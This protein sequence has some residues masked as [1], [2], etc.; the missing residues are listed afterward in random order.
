[1]EEG[2]SAL[3]APSPGPAAAAG[4]RGEHRAGDVAADER[5]H[6]HQEP[7]VPVRK[8][9]G[10]RE[11]GVPGAGQGV[12]PVPVWR[13]QRGRGRRQGLGGALGPLPGG[14]LLHLPL[15]LLAALHV[16]DCYGSVRLVR[17]TP[18]HIV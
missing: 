18:M 7:R 2:P 15:A 16:F 8:V 6:P 14:Q 9:H 5:A 1:M 11:G 3:A 4:A 17:T 12:P 13:G 10:D